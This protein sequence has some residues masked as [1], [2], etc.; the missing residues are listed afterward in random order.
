MNGPV[1]DTLGYKEW[2]T[3][4]N[5]LGIG[6]QCVLLRKGGIHEGRE[7]FSFRHERF[8]L[9]PTRFHA[10][11]ER[12]RVVGAVP[13]AGG[14][15]VVGDEVPVRFWC[16]A[17]WA[18]TLKS[19]QVV[20]QLEPFHIWNEE[21]VRERFDCGDVQ[22]IHCALVRVFGLPEPW[23]VPYA[24]KHGGCRTWIEL[25]EPPGNRRLELR[26]VIPDAQFSEWQEEIEKIVG[27]A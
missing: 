13:V 26:P 21:L 4:C 20:Q 11:L 15:W 5:A 18:R 3:V 22:Q 19:W 6:R 10:Q 14:E 8:F 17:A 24:R 9:F 27:K 25:P 1:E 12:V 7:G 2:E 23:M 16:E